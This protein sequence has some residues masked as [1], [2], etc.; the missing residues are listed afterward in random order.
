MTLFPLVALLSINGRQRRYRTRAIIHYAFKFF[1]VFLRFA[2]VLKIK[3]YDIG[4]LETM[5]GNLLICNHP[6]LLDV[7]IIMASLKNVQCIVNNKLWKNPF[8]G[9]I[10]RAAGYIRNDIDPELFLDQCMS[11]LARGENILIFPEGTRSIPDM[12]IKMHRGFANLA[13]AANVDIQLLLLTCQPT[14]LTKGAKWYEIPFKRATFILKRG[15]KFLSDDYNTETPRSIRVRALMRDVKQ[16][17]DG[18]LNN[19]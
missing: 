13:L 6:S 5:R 11:M 3:T 1:L 17:Y 4:P 19:G 10:V 18:N 14:W 12:P 7:V 8:V 2:R 16:Y 9:L 15:P